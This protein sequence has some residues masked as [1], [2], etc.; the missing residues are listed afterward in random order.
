MT[1][2]EGKNSGKEKHSL[3]VGVQTGTVPIEITEKVPLK[4]VNKSSIKSSY[5]TLH[6]KDCAY[7]YGGISLLRSTD[8]LFIIARYWKQLKCSSNSR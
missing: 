5:T 6:Q 2:D 1:T 7:Y 4:S 3:L 8:A